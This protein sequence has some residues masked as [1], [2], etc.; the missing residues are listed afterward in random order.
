MSNPSPTL[1]N[2]EAAIRTVI[3]CLVDGQKGLRKIGDELAD[4]TMKLYFLNES[5][6]RAEFRGEL[7]SI[8]HDEG[9]HSIAASGS[10]SATLN[11][12]WA[13]LKAKL[14]GGDQSLLETAE[15]D[16]HAA[17]KAYTQALQQELPFP[18]RQTLVSQAAR[19]QLFHEYVQAAR[20]LNKAL[21]SN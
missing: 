14:N 21:A 5:L 2:L 12:V 3:D 17:I 11:R 20:K 7:E 16:Q 10:V 15:Q 18:V 4:P 9:V 8:L 13:E 19:V 6:V 1:L